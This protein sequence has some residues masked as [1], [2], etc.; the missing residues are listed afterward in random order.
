MDRGPF[1]QADPRVDKPHR[2]HDDSDADGIVRAF[3][4]DGVHRLSEA[5]AE[6]RCP[7]HG[8]EL[9]RRA[10]AAHRR[11][12][13][14]GAAGGTRRRWSR[15][16]GAHLRPRS[17]DP[18]PARRATGRARGGGSV[19]GA[20]AGA[21]RL[22]DR[23]GRGAA[24]RIDLH[25]VREGR[26]DGGAGRGR[27]RVGSGRTPAAATGGGTGGRALLARTRRHRG[28]GS[29]RA[30]HAAG[31]RAL[32][33]LCRG[34]RPGG[35]GLHPGRIRHGLGCRATGWHQRGHRDRR[36]DRESALSAHADRDRGGRLR[37]VD[38]TGAH[39][40]F[41]GTAA[42]RDRPGVRRGLHARRPRH[43][44][45]APGHG[46][47]RPDCRLAVRGARGAAAAGRRLAGARVRVSVPGPDRARGLPSALPS[48]GQ[49]WRRR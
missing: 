3:P 37:R 27:A 48:L 12:R 23:G 16:R 33:R 22:P 39:V 11:L 29:V 38:W 2:A 43:G 8:G 30:L 40:G 26:I 19:A 35:R 49:R 1:S 42:A 36:D 4:S 28:A 44:G 31:V 25:G 21:R 24:G 34:A 47:A 41:S 5:G 15:A 7:H 10:R 32:R 18:V 13:V 6:A 46:R 9:A 17:P 14:H 45:V 20:P